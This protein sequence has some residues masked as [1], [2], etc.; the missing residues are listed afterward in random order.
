MTSPNET[1]LRRAIESDEIVPY[2]QPIV[3]LRSSLLTGFEV[4]AR[5]KH[6]ERGLIAPD[7][8]IPVAERAGLNG[9]LL[10]NLLRSTLAAAARISPHLTLSINISLTQLTDRT[11][12][13]HIR[14]AT[15]EAGFPLSRLILEIT[16]NALVG[17]TEHAYLIANELK[18]QGSRLALDDFGTGYSSLRHLQALPFDEIKIDASFVRSMTHTRESR[19]IAAAVIGLGNSLGLV[20][21][22]EGV[23]SATHAD[24]LLWLGC[25]RGQG[26]LYGRPVP[27]ES[28]YEILTI[29]TIFPPRVLRTATIEGTMP[30]RLEAFPTQR[31]AQLHAIYDG[32]PVGLGFLDRNLRFISVN[33]RLA[34]MD[35]LPV[36]SHLGRAIADVLPGWFPEFEPH[37][38]RALAGEAL[39]GIESYHPNP[40]DTNQ[41]TTFLVSFQPA[42]D[43]ANEVVGVSL[44]FVEAG[45]PGRVQPAPDETGEVIG[46]S[47]SITETTAPE[48]TAAEAPITRTAAPETSVAET[49]IAE[50][51]QSRPKGPTAYQPGPKA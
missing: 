35:N 50:T 51:T 11:L 41:E 48:T 18:D 29:R 15:D 37:L 40:L 31:L 4:L 26:F 45:R 17:D 20:T 21:V 34:A 3:E 38:H 42:L 47:L 24:M 43:E 25:E 16:E 5:W 33:K 39:T 2:F 46:I 10:A 28:L 8:F 49:I 7:F 23:E 6:P 27:P 44:C 19:K 14:Q 32:A 13:R 22:A 1:E 12:P 36:A 9:L 30:L